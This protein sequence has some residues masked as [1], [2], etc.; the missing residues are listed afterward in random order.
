M[1]S[2]TQFA[3]GATVG[4]A[5]LGKRLGVRRAAIAGG[6]LGTLPDL[7]VYIPVDDPV[8]SFVGHRGAT[9]SLIVHAL[10]TPLPQF[11]TPEKPPLRPP[12]EQSRG[13]RV[14]A[15]R[16]RA[17]CD[18]RECA[19][20]DMHTQKRS[21]S[22]RSLRLR[23]K[24]GKPAVPACPPARAAGPSRGARA[25]ACTLPL[26]RELSAVPSGL[27][28]CRA[29][30]VTLLVAPEALIGVPCLLCARESGAR[31]CLMM[32][33][34][35]EPHDGTVATNFGVPDESRL[36]LTAPSRSSAVAHFARC[37]GAG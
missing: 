6:L 5:V 31:L 28:L 32:A 22:A 14:R 12:D 36:R 35:Q 24:G 9:H 16:P 7:D 17:P 29:Q 37:G 18:P 23:E 27:S 25:P 2:V 8:E 1:D 3:L 33:R 21:E 20:R 10:I 30:S 34:H 19:E 15:A 26:C 4:A 13:A 11:V